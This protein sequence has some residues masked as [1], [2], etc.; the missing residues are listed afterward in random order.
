MI[1]IR[2]DYDGRKND[3][4]M[5]GH[6]HFQERRRR[7][8]L[9][10]CAQKRRPLVIKISSIRT[11][12]D[13]EKKEF[14]TR[15]TSKYKIIFNDPTWYHHITTAVVN[16]FEAPANW[17]GL[18]KYLDRKIDIPS[19]FLHH[20]AYACWQKRERKMKNNKKWKGI[21]N[22]EIT[23]THTEVHDLWVYLRFH[24]EEKGENKKNNFLAPSAKMTSL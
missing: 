13:G 20:L 5:A 21:K 17:S 22:V 6:K 15:M 3:Y 11:Q 14:S 23:N 24:C 8:I 18:E 12:G 10:M 4:C 1:F 7:E 16:E 19:S 9:M 2:C